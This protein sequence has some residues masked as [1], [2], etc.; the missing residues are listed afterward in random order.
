MLQYY[1]VLTIRNFSK[2]IDA[3]VENIDAAV[4][5]LT[6]CLLSEI[7]GLGPV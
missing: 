4:P 3:A 2:A 7:G 5:A 6:L 1:I